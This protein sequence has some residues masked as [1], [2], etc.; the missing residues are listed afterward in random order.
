MIH[1]KLKKAIIAWLFNNPNQWQRVNS[2]V[3]NFRTY[4]YDGAGNFLIGG[5]NVHDFIVE[6]EKL[7]YSKKE[8]N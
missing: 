1:M 4:I 8:E 7:I 3:E 5:K 2:C 6:A